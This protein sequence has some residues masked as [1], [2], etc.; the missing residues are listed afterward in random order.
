MIF[1]ETFGFDAPELCEYYQIE[2]FS[3][4]CVFTV[5]NSSRFLKQ[6][7]GEKRW[8]EYYRKTLSPVTHTFT[9]LDEVDD[10]RWRKHFEKLLD[11]AQD[12]LNQLRNKE[13]FLF[14]AHAWFDFDQLMSYFQVEEAFECYQPDDQPEM[15]PGKDF[16]IGSDGQP[17]TI[18]DLYRAAELDICTVEELCS[19]RAKYGSLENFLTI[20]ALTERKGKQ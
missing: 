14:N 12:L 19:I 2:V 8:M 16:I 17:I 10:I 6:Y 5:S 3:T 4:S 7:L 1:G 13:L 15:A 20:D 11:L 18:D 9:S